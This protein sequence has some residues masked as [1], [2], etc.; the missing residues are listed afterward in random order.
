MTGL[1]W[2]CCRKIARYRGAFLLPVVLLSGCYSLRDAGDAIEELPVSVGGGPTGGQ[3]DGGSG[4]ANT[5]GGSSTVGGGAYDCEESPARVAAQ[6]FYDAGNEIDASLVRR[7]WHLNEP[8]SVM[9]IVPDNKS[10]YFLVWD[11]VP[12]VPYQGYL[13]IPDLSDPYNITFPWLVGGRYWLHGATMVDG[14]LKATLPVSAAHEE[15]CRMQTPHAGPGSCEFLGYDYPHNT[16]TCTANAQP[17]DCWWLRVITS[18]IC[19]CDVSGCFPTQGGNHLTY[20]LEIDFR[21][22]ELP[23]LTLV[24]PSPAPGSPD[25]SGTFTPTT[26]TTLLIR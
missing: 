10:A 15:W 2:L 16:A 3:A 14:V 11:Y 9:F 18:S 5:V 6:A 24:G 13:D 20:A 22:P 25:S 1:F 8:S 21:D 19:S 23:V 7:G 26:E 4:G 17:V 12:P